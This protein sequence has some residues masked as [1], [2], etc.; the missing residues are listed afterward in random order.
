MSKKQIQAI[1]PPDLRAHFRTQWETYPFDLKLRKPRKTKL[2]DF[3]YDPELAEKTNGK[4]KYRITLNQDMPP[5][6]FCLTYLHEF[7]HLLVH[8]KFGRKVDPHGKEWKKEFSLLI[9]EVRE[10]E[11][12]NPPQKAALRKI[13]ANPPASLSSSVALYR[14]FLPELKENE[15]LVSSIKEGNEFRF[16]GRQ[17]RLLNRIRTRAL[18]RE[19]KSGKRFYFPFSMRVE[20]I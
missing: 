6:L 12:F 2:G 3:R 5:A 16:E 7:A 19:I 20:L 17:F 18:C 13:Q 14:P 10:H 15:I 9:G 4:K 1:L 11:L 8:E